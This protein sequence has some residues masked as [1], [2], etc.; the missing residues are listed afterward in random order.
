MFPSLFPDHLADRHF[1][2]QC[3]FICPP[4]EKL[5]FDFIGRFENL[6][7]D[8][9]YIAERFDFDPVLPHRNASNPTMGSQNY[10][11]PALLE[12]GSRTIQR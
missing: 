12:G 8:W 3:C 7:E 2:R 1:K 9:R 6:A 5:V 11:T 4:G 10:Y